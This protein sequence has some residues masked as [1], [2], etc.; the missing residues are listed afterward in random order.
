MWS[1][2]NTKLENLVPVHIQTPL[3]VS[4]PHPMITAIV[5]PKLK[6]SH[7]VSA[8]FVAKRQIN[9]YRYRCASSKISIQLWTF[10]TCEWRPLYWFY[11][12]LPLTDE[13]MRAV[14]SV[15]H[16][17]QLLYSDIV[18]RIAGLVILQRRWCS[19]VME[20]ECF[21]MLWKLRDISAFVCSGL[22][23]C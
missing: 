16:G 7:T 9:F 13:F 20:S 5:L 2:P 3:D 8:H 19:T 12:I 21:L 15:V 22:L 10:K 4:T 18:A 1:P 23:L 11:C 6:K 17:F 14:P